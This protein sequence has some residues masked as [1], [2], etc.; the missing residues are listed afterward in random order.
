MYKMPD[1]KAMNEE[2]TVSGVRVL[3]P[4]EYKALLRGCSKPDFRTIL[5]TML[6]T[7]MRY[8]EMKRF[9]DHPE[10]WTGE[11]IHLPKEASL[12]HKRTQKERWVRLNQPGKMAV[13]YFLRCDKRLPSYQSWSENMKCWGRRGG[14]TPIGL[15]V[16]TTRKTIESW[17]MFYYPDFFPLILL[18]QG[19]NA[20][21]ALNHYLNLPFTESDRVEMK[22]FVIGWPPPKNHYDR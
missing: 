20:V 18:S 7:G 8:V 10:W 19:H 2:I 9:Q 3:R 4:L 21:T 16:K 12:K 17:L 14:I 11:F 1:Y 5:Q 6:Y 22:N 15:S 13:E